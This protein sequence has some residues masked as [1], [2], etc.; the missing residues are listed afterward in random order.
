MHHSTVAAPIPVHH[1]AKISIHTLVFADKKRDALVIMVLRSCSREVILMKTC[2]SSAFSV[3]IHAIDGRLVPLVAGI[4][5]ASVFITSCAVRPKPSPLHQPPIRSAIRG[6][7]KWQGVCEKEKAHPTFNNGQARTANAR[8]AERWAN[9][10]ATLEDSP[11][12]EQIRAINA[13]FNTWPYKEDRDNW[14]VEDYWA[15][16]G[17][18]MERS[19]DCED[20]VIAKYFALRD[21]G[22][23][24]DDLRIAGVW[25]LRVNQGHALLLVK[26]GD[27]TWVL[28]NL[29]V[30]PAPETAFQNYIP[31]YYANELFMW[32]HEKPALRG[33][34]KGT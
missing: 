3:S 20:Y 24:P 34:M 26:D 33:M 30:E 8:A 27:T 16:P 14:G 19:G 2:L 29:A 4:V 32:T 12:L 1:V 25:N 10:R 6:F 28:D 23:T 15:T 17:E 22:L 9:L 11:R 21:L 7:S 18:F 13:F 31:R 5:L